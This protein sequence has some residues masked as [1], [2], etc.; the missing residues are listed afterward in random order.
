MWVS[1]S[2]PASGGLQIGV[3]C[4]CG[5]GSWVGRWV[6]VIL[7]RWVFQS[8]SLRQQNEGALRRSCT[9]WGVPKPAMHQTRRRLET[10]VMPRQLRTQH[11]MP[12]PAECA[13]RTSKAGATSS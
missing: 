1:G 11:S 10:S 4:A 7:W 9:A 5:G 12:M 2:V 3:G 8:A 6:G 13:C